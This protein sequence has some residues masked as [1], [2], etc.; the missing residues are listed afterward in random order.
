MYSIKWTAPVSFGGNTISKLY[1]PQKKGD[2]GYDIPV[3]I[4]RQDMNF[5]E[6]FVRDV[7]GGDYKPLRIIWPF[8]SKMLHSKVYIE[9][10]DD[11]WAKIEG[12]SSASK[13]KMI[14]LG[15]IIDSGYRGEYFTVLY[16]SSF[17]PR[18]VRNGERYAQVVFHHAIRPA[19]T[20]SETI[21]NT[22]RGATGFGATGR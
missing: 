17:V 7:L 10:P 20:Y 5:I 1:T 21:N 3:V 16:N 8:T 14:V 12:R 2:V 4:E 11:L 18:I 22:D 19:A 15:G 6:Q 13:K 9:L